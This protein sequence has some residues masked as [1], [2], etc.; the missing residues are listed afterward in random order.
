MRGSEL[1]ATR[2]LIQFS[3][4]LPR[5]LKVENTL[6]PTRQST[7]GILDDRVAAAKAAETEE[8]TVCICTYR[9][10]ELLE[11]LLV[12]LAKQ[13]TDG[14][15]HFSCVVVDNDGTASARP[16]IERLQPT[17]P[18]PIRYDVE[19]ARNFALV[20]NRAIGLASG[21]LF[22]FIDDDEVPRE[23][24]LIQMLR[25]LD[26]HGADAVL[27]PVRPYFEGEP[28][29]WIVRSG[30]C[31]RPPHPTGM[32]LHW[33]QTRTGNVL[34]R[35]AMIKDEG[36]RFD[37]A[38]ASGGEDIDFFRRAAGAG[39]NFVWCEEGA[40]YELV[41]ESRLRRSYHLKRA[42]LQGRLSL[43]YATDRP[44]ITA[45][46]QV[47]AKA[48]TAAVLYTTA[49]PVLFLMGHHLGMKYL[50]KD[51][52]HVGRLLAMAGIARSTN[53]NF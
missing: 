13:R 40:V 38:Y 49:L 39:K 15:F 31:D 5:Y 10:P 17:L 33:R 29:R 18:F 30:V 19:P 20:R 47:A 32:V 2:V 28:P 4:P 35:A 21:K 23:D 43:K 42:F 46:L 52:H 48:L 22:A 16:L 50:V 34:L 14:R 53:R 51:C 1:T 7:D 11:R 44:T 27:G 24:W 45:R 37:P 36:L 6:T 26:E 41:P 8:I 12:A 25:V 9:R 3:Q